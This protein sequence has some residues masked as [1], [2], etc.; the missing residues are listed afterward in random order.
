MNCASR[1]V[2]AALLA[3]AA[4]AQEPSAKGVNFYSLEREIQLGQQTAGG[5][6][7]TLPAVHDA[8]LEGYIAGLG[9]ELARYAGQQFVYRFTFYDDRKPPVVPGVAL[10]LPADAF[11][12]QA[13]EPV[14][15]A[16]GPIFVPLSLLANAPSE[17]EFAFQLA[18]A[19]A[20]VALRHATKLATRNELARVAGAL[21]NDMPANQQFA[22][23]LGLL[24]FA[25]QCE[26]QADILAADIVA[27]AGYDPAAAISVAPDNATASRVF[28]A[29]PTREQRAAAIKARIE[30]LPPREYSAATGQFAGMKA[31]AAV[32]R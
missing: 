30:K 26:L 12:G 6:E 15:I 24:N 22:V 17:A 2:P 13:A 19:M 32:A 31:L 29:H 16:G 25:R 5:L 8:K 21:L 1:G 3:L 18:H 14:A 28:S 20:H 7:R 4:F 10:A 23:P 27:G 9:S 11:Q